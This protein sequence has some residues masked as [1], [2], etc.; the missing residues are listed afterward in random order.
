MTVTLIVLALA[1]LMIAV[2]RLKPNRRFPTVSGW[3]ARALAVNLVQVGMVFLAGATWDGWM[4][5]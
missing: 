2:E 5:R 1:I 4:I 3:W